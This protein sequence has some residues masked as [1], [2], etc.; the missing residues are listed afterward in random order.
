M[1]KGKGKSIMKAKLLACGISKRVKIS[2][3]AAANM[4]NKRR[5]GETCQWVGYKDIFLHISFPHRIKYE[6]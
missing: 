6:V 4:H 2:G 3:A 1:Q 5:A